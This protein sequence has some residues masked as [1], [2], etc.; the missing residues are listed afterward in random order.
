MNDDEDDQD[1]TNDKSVEES[2]ERL[3]YVLDSIRKHKLDFNQVSPAG[4]PVIKLSGHYHYPASGDEE[5]PYEG[6]DLTA[7]EYHLLEEKM[8]D[9]TVAQTTRHNETL[10]RWEQ[11]IISEI[12]AARTQTPDLYRLPE[13]ERDEI[14][15]REIGYFEEVMKKVNEE[16]EQED[17][18]PKLSIVPPPKP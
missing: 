17:K 13:H 16:E 6:Y 2:A 3:A 9:I 18:K 12:I 7:E 15:D 1:I 5:Y 4:R 14:M 11:R 8:A 10:E